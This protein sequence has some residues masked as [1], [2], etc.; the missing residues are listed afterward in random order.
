MT[1]IGLASSGRA[2]EGVGDPVGQELAV[3]QARGRVVEGAALRDVDE[4][5]VV[6][7]DRGELGE[8]GQ[9]LDLA[10]SER[11]SDCPEARPITPTTRPPDSG[12]RRRRRRAVPAG[13]PGARRPRVVV[14]DRDRL[15]GPD[16]RAGHAVARRQDAIPDEVGEDADADAHDERRR[17]RFE[18]VDE[19]RAGVPSSAEARARIVAEESVRS[20]GP[21]ARGPCRRGR[22]GT[23][24]RAARRRAVG[25]SGLARYIARSAIATSSSLVRPSSGK[26]ATPALIV[27]RADVDARRGRLRS[28]TA[29][30]DPLGHVVGGHAVGARAGS[31]RTRR[32]RTDRAGRR[33][34]SRSP[35]RAAISPGERRRPDGRARR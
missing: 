18:Q 24:R 20:C 30:P 3:R 29:A 23:D 27:T 34:G 21:A 25:R 12:G 13:R 26:Q 11:P 7:R 5:R 2:R 4:T 16:D 15:A 31:R 19:A 10:L 14:I 28:R 9:R 1:A 17:V 35:S 22:E 32:R 33:R 8:A 6:E